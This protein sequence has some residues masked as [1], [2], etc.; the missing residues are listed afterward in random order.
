V[1]AVRA[2]QQMTP[3]KARM[4]LQSLVRE[5]PYVEVESERAPQEAPPRS[6]AVSAT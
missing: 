6:L 4:Y 2:D 1:A 3:E 5:Y